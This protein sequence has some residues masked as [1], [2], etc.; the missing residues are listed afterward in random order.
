MRNILNKLNIFDTFKK[1]RRANNAVKES[2]DWLYIH[3]D[4]MP[5]GRVYE[6]EFLGV[7]WQA[8][9]QEDGFVYLDEI[10]T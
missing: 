10:D 1:R 4:D 7:H 5:V 2:A 3:P 8:I 9:K 6:V